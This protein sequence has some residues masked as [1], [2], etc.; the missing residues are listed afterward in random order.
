[1]KYGK[2]GDLAEGLEK[3]KRKHRATGKPRGGRTYLEQPD[4]RHVFTPELAKVILERM[5][6]G[7]TVA[8]ICRSHPKMPTPRAVR[9]WKYDVEGFGAAYA[10]AREIRAE[11]W[12]DDL[13]TLADD[14][15]IDPSTRR[16]EFD[17]K[18]WL[19]S[20]SAPQLYGDK[21]TL[22]GDPNAPLRHVELEEVIQSLSEPE[23]LALERFTDAVIAAR[24]G[25][26]ADDGENSL[27]DSGNSSGRSRK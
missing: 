8:D 20:K 2:S 24:E 16:V 11:V 18:K 14:R 3:P 15:A 19:M 27:G 25:K 17:I 7:E 10:R 13:K 9:G 22:A 4:E 6:D 5:A 26:I 21:V 23:L 12:E 1:M